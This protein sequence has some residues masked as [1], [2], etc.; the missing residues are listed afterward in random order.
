[1]VCHTHGG[2]APQVKA[3]ARERLAALVEPAI[4]VL[5]DLIRRR[6][7]LPMAALGAARDVLDRAGYKVAEPVVA[8]VMT[9]VIHVHESAAQAGAGAP[10]PLSGAL[11]AAVVAEADPPRHR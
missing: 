1:M 9:Q 6:G 2:A 7:K 11:P 5:G 8:A 10:S 4:G 3:R